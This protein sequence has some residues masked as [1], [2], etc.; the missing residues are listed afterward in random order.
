M[1]I[2]L[3]GG[4]GQVGTV[5]ARHFHDAGHDVVVLSRS[6]DADRPWRVIA[7]DARAL[8]DWAGELDG[9]DAVINLA[10]RSVDCRY[11]PANR[12]LIKD[13][14]VDATRTVGDAVARCRTPPGVWLQ[15][16]TATIYRHTKEKDQ[17]EATGTLGVAEDE[18]DT[19][20][21]S[22]DVAKSWEDAARAA[23][24]P[25]T[26]QVL[27][28]TAMV[29]SPDR[30]GVF[31]V[32]SRL[33]RF[34][35]GGR[36]GS[37]RQYVS[38][39]HDVDLC[40]A[41][42]FLIAGDDLAGPVNLAAPNPLPHAEFM[43]HLRHA[44]GRRVGLPATKWMIEVAAVFMRTESELILKSR[45]VV[46]GRLADAGF[47]FDFPAWPDAAADLVSRFRRPAAEHRG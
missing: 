44:W 11:T 27:L 43:R 21:F 7:W 17:D 24:T 6:T 34:G 23:D 47:T 2:V 45:R 26:R 41:I 37:G 8:G 4:S 35:L 12:R 39:L 42:D 15:M 32:L 18:P 20:H 5:L 46:P 36:A 1:R 16:S 29:M 19:W 14:R 22:Y 40:R 10:G 38:W 3:P 28:R 9:A 25:G 13:S 30:G 33:A 31:E